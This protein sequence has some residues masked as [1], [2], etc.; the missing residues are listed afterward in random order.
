[1]VVVQ[2]GQLAPRALPVLL[3]QLFASRHTGALE[4]SFTPAEGGPAS[5]AQIFF[6]AGYPVDVLVQ[7]SRDRLGVVLIENGLLDRDRY[8]R[9]QSLR[10]TAGKLIGDLM[11]AARLLDRRALREGLRAQVRR[12]LHA[13]FAQ[14]QGTFQLFAGSHSRG[15]SDG[16]S[17]ASDPRRIIFFGARRAYT[18]AQLHAGLAPLRGFDVQLSAAEAAEATRWLP[19]SEQRLAQLLLRGA[20][21]INDLVTGSQVHPNSALAFLYTYLLTQGLLL[22]SAGSAPRRPLAPGVAGA[23]MTPPF[24]ASDEPLPPDQS[25]V[26]E[27]GRPVYLRSGQQTDAIPGAAAQPRLLMTLEP[28]TAGLSASSRGVTESGGAMSASRDDALQAPAQPVR[29]TAPRP[30]VTSEA[31]GAATTPRASARSRPAT[32]PGP[33]EAA[34]PAPAAPVVQ[35]WTAPPLRTSLPTARLSATPSAPTPPQAP[36]RPGASESPTEAKA[37]GASTGSRPAPAGSTPTVPS[38]GQRPHSGASGRPVSSGGTPV[39]SRPPSG[40]AGT[41]VLPRPPSGGSRPSG[42]SGLRLIERFAPGMQ[43]DER[44]ANTP[45]RPPPVDDEPRPDRDRDRDRDDER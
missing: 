19:P 2:T 21:S 32:A 38:A 29:V 26:A 44:T 31:E 39:L 14:E 41:P 24:Q 3:A 10:P 36:R 5:R 15:V 25:P 30:A 35:T 45:K 6:R 12:R 22:L 42:R 27:L 23:P 33:V 40:S 4:L 9:A 11:L 37:R 43:R 7:E 8:L 13:L 17:L 34:P 1:M 18:A 28:L 16:E 20:W